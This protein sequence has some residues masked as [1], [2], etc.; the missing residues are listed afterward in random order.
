MLYCA[1]LCSTRLYFT[2]LFCTVLHCTALSC[3]LYTKNPRLPARAINQYAINGTIAINQSSPMHLQCTYSIRRRGPCIFL[4]FY[5]FIGEKIRR[6]RPQ[7]EP[8]WMATTRSRCQPLGTLLGKPARCAR[9]VRDVT[10]QSR[11]CHQT[12]PSHSKTPQNHPTT[13]NLPIAQLS[14]PPHF[15]RGSPSNR[16][17]ACCRSSCRRTQAQL[18]SVSLSTSFHVIHHQ[19][20]PLPEIPHTRILLL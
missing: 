11:S 20:S 13:P 17:I 2:V 15:R 16:A 19:T 6:V 4:S 5:R 18:A 3:T 7:K 12:S 8:G 14:H 1:V 9:G 10:R